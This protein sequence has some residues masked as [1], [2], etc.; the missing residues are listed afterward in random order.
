MKKIFFAFTVLFSGIILS[1]QD[2]P[3]FLEVDYQMEMK[4]DFEEIIKNVPAQFRSQVEEPLKQEIQ[5]GI[6]VNYKLKTNGSESEYKMQEQINNDQ[7][8]SGIILQQITAMDKEPLYKDIKAGYYLKPMDV[9]KA[10]LM[11]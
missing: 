3:Q 2:K 9:G 5:K 11:K 7:S 6:F 8:M 10:Y 1:A 4:F